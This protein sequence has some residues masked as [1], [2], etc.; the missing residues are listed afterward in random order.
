MARRRNRLSPAEI[1]TVECGLHADG[2]GL[3]LRVTP[4]VAGRLNKSWVFRYSS[5]G[6]ERRMGLGALP[7]VGLA[8]A[9]QQADECRRLWLEGV[10]PIAARQAASRANKP[11]VRADGGV[12]MQQNV[13]AFIG[14]ADISPD[15]VGTGQS[16]VANLLAST[17]GRRSLGDAQAGEILDVLAS[18]WLAR[19]ETAGGA[20][21][22]IDPSAM[23]Q[24]L[25]VRGHRRASTREEPNKRQRKPGSDRAP[26]YRL[27][28]AFIADLRA[29]PSRP[30]T[31]LAF[32]WLVLTASRTTETRFA[33]WQEIDESAALWA[34][35]AE[36]TAMGRPHMV[37]LSARCLEILEAAR[38][39]YPASDL[40]F[41]GSNGEPLSDMTFT[42]VLRDL[43]Y[44]REATPR[45]MIRAFKMWCEEAAV[46]R[47]A[48]GQAARVSALGGQASCL[49]TDFLQ[50]QRALMCA[51]AECCL[52]GISSA[53]GGP[54]GRSGR[55]GAGGQWE[56]STT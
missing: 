15:N 20:R 42:M 49:D 12:A 36:R 6:R 28:P 52:Q 22:R 17:L 23:S 54:T 47:G 18:L 5:G 38:T 43:G 45:G 1:E 25:S 34:I 16:S 8:D 40:L 53:S 33:Q 35:P 26:D 14:A 31:K 19:S 21:R 41:P 24:T 4:G 55:K 51:W 32:E 11:A 2:G 39:L 50:Q 13:D 9:R 29:K 27:I 37:P 56:R 7:D 3:Y 46:A 44:A 48:G 30:A 10:D